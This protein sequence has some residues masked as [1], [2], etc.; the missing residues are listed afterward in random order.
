MKDTIKAVFPLVKNAFKSGQIFNPKA[1]VTNPIDDVHAEYDVK[2]LL[3]DSTHVL[4]NVFKSKKAMAEDRALPVVMC[5]H[6]YDNHNIA[7]LK[8]DKNTPPSQYRIINQNGRP[9]FSTQTSWESPDP[10]F[11]VKNGYIVVN[12]NM[13][14]YA[15]SEGQATTFRYN[16]S[17]AYY[18]AIN[19]VAAQEWCDGNVGLNGVSFLAI[20]QFHVAA[21]K[22][23]GYEAP[24]ALKCIVPWEGLTDAYRDIFCN[25]GIPQIGFPAFWYPLELKGTVTDDIQ[26]FLDTEGGKPEHWAFKHP[27][28]DEFWKE[29]QTPLEHIKVPIL[30]CASFSDVGLHSGGA[31]RSFTDVAST[32]KWMY[33]HRDGKWDKYYSSEVQA[34]TLRF[35]DHFLKGKEN[36][37]DSVPPVHLEVQKDRTTVH[38]IRDEHEWPLA[39]TQYIPYFLGVSEALQTDKAEQEMSVTYEAK[40]GETSFSITFD[41]DTEIT[42]HA[43]LK[44]FVSLEESSSNDIDLFAV[45]NKRDRSGN[46]VPFNGTVGN[47]QD[48][49]SRGYQRA[50]LRKLDEQ[51]STDIIPFLAFD[52]HQYLSENEVVELTIPF[53]P[54]SVFFEKGEAL[55][56]T[57]SSHETYQSAPFFKRPDANIDGKHRIHFGGQYDAL[58]Q[59]PLIR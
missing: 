47:Q 50:S 29:K 7:A 2:V 59:L 3:S 8:G 33:M 12:M 46:R 16:Q 6:P 21:T 13:P 49:L 55:E 22:D 24:D 41:E 56:L 48:T 25:G 15:G 19:W 40:K 10:N 53:P 34:L 36:G 31:Y 14:G 35:M 20:T 42:G 23:Y 58:L 43:K 1:N 38:E 51:K 4:V 9:T 39:R 52:E 5:A 26:T 45:L 32:Q 54:V 30:T 17:K 44:L 57:L 37:M 27:L 18:E 28:F 11:W